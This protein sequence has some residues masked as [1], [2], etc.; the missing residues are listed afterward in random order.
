[1]KNEFLEVLQKKGIVHYS[2]IPM[3]YT[4]LGIVRKRKIILNIKYKS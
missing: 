3:A 2:M 4:S 1:M